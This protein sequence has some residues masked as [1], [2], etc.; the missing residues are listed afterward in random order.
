M[1]EPSSKV[2]SDR[3]NQGGNQEAGEKWREIFSRTLPRSPAPLLVLLSL[4]LY[5]STLA[6]DILDSDGGEFQF[7]AWNFSFVHP[8]GYPLFLL[9][10]GIFQHLLPIGSPAFRLNVFNA[11]IAAC[12]VG[13]VYLAAHEITGERIG[14]LLGAASFAVSR[15]FWFNAS[16]VEV[17]A[18]NALFLVFLIF[19][20]VRWKNHPSSRAFALICLTYGLALAHHRTIGLWL[21][22]FAL[23]FLLTS[24]RILRSGVKVHLSALRFAFFGLC[25]FLPLLLYAYVPLRVPASPYYQLPLGSNSS[26]TLYDNSTLGFINYVL[27]RTFAVELKWDALSVIRLVSTPQLLV[28]EFGVLGAVLG[29]VGLG[30]LVLRRAWT[31]LAFAGMGVGITLF[32]N[33]IYH[34]GDISAYYIPLYLIW[35]LLISSISFQIPRSASPTSKLQFQLS[36]HPWSLALLLG[37]LLIGSQ[38]FSN[39]QFADRT[40]ENPRAQWTKI[41]AAPIPQSAVLVSN[42]RDEMMPLWYLQYVDKTRPD[43]LGLFPLITPDPKYSNVGRLTD[44]LLDSGRPIY[45]I[46]PMPGMEIKFRLDSSAPPLVRVLGR[47][48]EFAPQHAS[49]AIIANRVRVL[50]YDLERAANTLRIRIYLQAQSKLERNYTAYVQLVTPHGTK[51]AQ[52]DDHQLGGEFYP[53]TLWQSGE[54]LVDVQTIPL[55]DVPADTYRLFV[56]LYTQPNLTLF[57]DAEVGFVSIQ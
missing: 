23:Y 1:N 49:D 48:T 57:G 34:I 50:G 6:P 3:E 56:G 51:A 52:G 17:Y 25:F 20:A 45:F 21:P 30:A 54:T 42:D 53:T 47:A 12:A 55:T 28:T 4:V 19:L 38:V 40:K 27:G 15:T 39:F 8:T 36:T 32:F 46:K 29:I 11:L 14:A 24:L 22:A 31:F 16:G 9:L 35:A 5:L 37:V 18:L 13:A 26:I 2:A 10:G 7:A 41:L 43:L 44:T 33:A